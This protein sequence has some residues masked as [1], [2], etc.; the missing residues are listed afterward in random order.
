MLGKSFFPTR[1]PHILIS[2][3]LGAISTVTSPQVSVALKFIV[4]AGGVSL[5]H[6]EKVGKQRCLALFR[7]CS[8]SVNQYS[9]W[10]ITLPHPP[11]GKGWR[12]LPVLS[13]ESNKMTCCFPNCSSSLVMMIYIS[14]TRGN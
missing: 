1:D 12:N 5:L 13:L 8:K 9:V 10:D 11:L 2:S 4:T 6:S 14:K 7:V 3:Y